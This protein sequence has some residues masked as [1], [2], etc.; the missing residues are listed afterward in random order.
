MEEI[1]PL[2]NAAHRLYRA[3]IRAC[4]DIYMLLYSCHDTNDTLLF[5]DRLINS[6]T[7]KT[8]ICTAVVLSFTATTGEYTH[9]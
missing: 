9:V 7:M 3:I 4:I 6:D 5:S 2:L 1:Q 8:F